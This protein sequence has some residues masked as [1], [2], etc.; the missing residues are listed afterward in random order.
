MGIEVCLLVKPV[1][2]KILTTTYFK[3]CHGGLEF[4]AYNYVRDNGIQ[5][6]ATYPY[7]GRVRETYSVT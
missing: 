1:V 4:K 3:G 5:S 6:E 7:V 2:I